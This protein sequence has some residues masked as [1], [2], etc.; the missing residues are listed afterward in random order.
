LYLQE[1]NKSWI[2]IGKVTSEYIFVPSTNS[3]HTAGIGFFNLTIANDFPASQLAFYFAQTFTSI[4]M[5]PRLTFSIP[6]NLAYCPETA[7]N[8]SSFFFPGGFTWIVDLPPQFSQSSDFDV[9]MLNASVGLRVDFWDYDASSIP[10]LYYDS[11]GSCS[12][13]GSPYDAFEVCLGMSPDDDYVLVARS[14]SR[15]CKA[16]K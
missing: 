10:E 8:C 3:V 14:A 15:L 1:R 7:A 9:L 4:L 5:D 6:R 11:Y 12:V 13:Y 16:D 2:A